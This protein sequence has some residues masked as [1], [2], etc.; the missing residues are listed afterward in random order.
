MHA[1]AAISEGTSARDRGLVVL[2]GVC[3]GLNWVAVKLALEEV[4]PWTLRC[5]GMGLGAATLL[6]WAWASGRSLRIAPGAPRRQLAVAGTLNIAAFGLFTAFAQMAATTSRVTIVTYTMPIWSVLFARWVLGERLDGPR[7][8]AVALAAAGI[9]VLVAPLARDGVPPGLWWALAA[10]VSW[11]AG[12]VYL[13][14]A[15]IG[16][17]PLAIAGW[18]LVAGFVVVALGAVLLERG[19]QPWPALASTWAALVYH[20]LLG[21][22]LPYLLWFG[23]VARLPA[24]TAALGTLLVPAVAVAGA[25][26]L[27]AERPTLADA[28]GFVLVFAAAATVLMR[29]APAV[30]LASGA[31][32]RP[33]GIVT[34][35]R[36]DE[37]AR[38]R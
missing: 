37:R 33:R 19:V 29:P 6:A 23:I 34:G 38:P 11:A 20:V 26:L 17:D 10:A 22:A 32:T 21:I 18:Q 1:A 8:L 16:G 13:K 2:L 30:A 31:S 9:A 28:I 12:T 36:I 24:S 35:E 3:W 15:R 5:V 27:L 7:R 4:A 25:V 14:R